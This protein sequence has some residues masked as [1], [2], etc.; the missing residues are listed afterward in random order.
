MRHTTYSEYH[1]SFTCDA[2]VISRYIFATR[3]VHLFCV[4]HVRICR[5]A[6]IYSSYHDSFTSDARL[7]S[8]NCLHNHAFLCVAPPPTPPTPSIAELRKPRHAPRT[9]VRAHSSIKL[10]PR[11]T[12]PVCVRDSVRVRVCECVRERECVCVRMLV[13]VCVCVCVVVNMYAY[14]SV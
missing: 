13:C 14:M 11:A 10:S 8:R 1:D 5:V 9:N 3:H 12:F 4:E 7:I 2:R 6:N